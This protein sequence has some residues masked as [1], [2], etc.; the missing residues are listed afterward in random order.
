LLL[1]PPV[2]QPGPSAPFEPVTFSPQDITPLAEFI[3]MALEADRSDKLKSLKIDLD[4]LSAP[5][6]WILPEQDGSR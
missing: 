1:K 4:W 3:I 6:L 5:A 2:L